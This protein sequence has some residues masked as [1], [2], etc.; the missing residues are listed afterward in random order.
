MNRDEQADDAA[1]GYARKWLPPALA[2]DEMHEPNVC[3]QHGP[4]NWWKGKWGE[5]NF[6]CNKCQKENE[7][8]Q[9]K[10]DN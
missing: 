9:V 6:V 10:E 1:R 5:Q 7:N 8:E 4:M 3:P 2:D